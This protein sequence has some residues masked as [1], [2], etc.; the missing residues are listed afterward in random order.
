MAALA[1]HLVDGVI[2]DVP[3]R[4]WV[5]SLPIA[6]RLHLAADPSLCRRIASAFIDAVFAS[7][8]RRAR[9][10]GAL[11][12]PGSLVYPGAV[13]FVQRFG[14]NLGLNERARYLAL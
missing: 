5:L 2:P 4:Q 14:S 1:A 10:A 9:S 8:V 11:D 12:A 13:N 6:L 3:T 7:Y